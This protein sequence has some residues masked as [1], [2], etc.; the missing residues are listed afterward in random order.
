M[1][2]SID[3]INGVSVGLEFIPADEDEYNTIIVDCVILRLLIQW[4]IIE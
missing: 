4:P 3:L 1:D 2:L